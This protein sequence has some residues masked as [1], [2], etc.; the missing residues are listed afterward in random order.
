MKKTAIA[1]LDELK[2]RDPAYAILGEV[3]LVVVRIDDDV[4]VF[5]GRCLHRGALMAD[6]FVRGKSLICGVHYWDYRLDSGVSSY[7]N[8]EA[9][10]KFQ[11]WVDKGAVLVDEDEINAWAQANPQPYNRKAYL[12]LYADPSHGT[13]EEP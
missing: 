10:P 1:Q 7:N 5:Y 2:D 9:L 13:E 6:G 8:D 11:C 4:S 3:D 12:G